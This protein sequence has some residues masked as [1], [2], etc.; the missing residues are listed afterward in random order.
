V[1]LSAVQFRMLQYIPDDGLS[2]I[3]LRQGRPHR[4]GARILTLRILVDMGLVVE[5][6][7]AHDFRFALT[8]AGRALLR[9]KTA[10]PSS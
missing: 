7:G 1:K 6:E 10:E 8:D 9:S 4:V 5:L 3:A 2:L